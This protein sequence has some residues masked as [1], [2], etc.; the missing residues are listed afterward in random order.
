[1]AALEQTAQ[2]SVITTSY[3]SHSSPHS[4]DFG[5]YD[6]KQ[7]LKLLFK[8]ENMIIIHYIGE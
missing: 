2:Q 8:Q 6:W 3:T 1:M 4:S 5:P 7:L